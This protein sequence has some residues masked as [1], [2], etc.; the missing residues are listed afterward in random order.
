MKYTHHEGS[1]A[2]KPLELEITKSAVYLRR[3]IEQFTRT[4]QD[5]NEVT[6]WGYDEAQLTPDEYAEYVRSANSQAVETLMQMINDVSASQMESDVVNQS[7]HDEAMQLM[8]DVQ[9][10]IAMI[11][12]TATV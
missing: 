9:A 7:N 8:N 6:L 12:A 3:N 5:G 4:E 10:D 11:S 1:Q 2:E